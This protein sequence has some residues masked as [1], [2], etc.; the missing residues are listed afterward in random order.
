MFFPCFDEN[1]EVTINKVLDYDADGKALDDN[2]PFVEGTVINAGNK[3]RV[4]E[5]VLKIENISNSIL[6]FK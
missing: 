5:G 4:V 3:T 6:E 2:T 1:G